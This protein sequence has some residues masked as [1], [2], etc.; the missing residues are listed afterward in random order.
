GAGRPGGPAGLRGTAGLRARRAGGL[1]GAGPV[2]ARAITAAQRLRQT[3]AP[4]AA[5]CSRTRCA[6]ARCASA[7]RVWRAG[8]MAR[9]PAET[10]RIGR[11]HRK[12][13]GAD[14]IDVLLNYIRV[15]TAPGLGCPGRTW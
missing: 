12:G 1:Q 14:N 13:R 10:V 2:G 15:G 7:S 4:A 5:R 6:R 3:A 8:V 9:Y 11:A